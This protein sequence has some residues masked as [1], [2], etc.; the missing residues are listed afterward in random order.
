MIRACCCAKKTNTK[1]QS[2]VEP[3]YLIYLHFY[4]ASSIEMSA[5][6][7]H[8]SSP[9][10]TKQLQ[11]ARHHYTRA[12]ELIQAEDASMARMSLQSSTNSSSLH[13]PS[14]SISSRTW[15][16]STGFSSPTPS[17]YSL[18]DAFVKAETPT[19]IKKR[20]TFSDITEPIIR[21][22][23]PTLGFDEWLGRSTPDL[24]QPTPILK[25]L[26]PLP[27]EVLQQQEEEDSPAKMEQDADDAIFLRERS[28]R[29]YCAVL[30]GLSTQLAAHLGAVEAELAGP[31]TKPL[32]VSGRSTPDVAG[33]SDAMRAL[34]IQSRIERLKQNGWQR[35]RFDARRYE[36]LRESVMAELA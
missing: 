11:Q 13:S 2:E 27:V 21:P 4:A 10:K 15:S 24:L 5:R 7:F 26:P 22:D 28:A 30:T 31:A 18:N 20:V 32:P 17:L 16:A 8:S 33:A 12:R 35:R 25:P 29:R 19:P 9:Y 6:A 36:A 34:D 1:L 23:S 3:A 14:G